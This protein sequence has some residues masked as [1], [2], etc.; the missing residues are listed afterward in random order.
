MKIFFNPWEHII[1]SLLSSCYNSF[2]TIVYFW[3]RWQFFFS[4]DFLL[5]GFFLVFT[6]VLIR[7]WHQHKEPLKTPT[8]WK[9][10][11][12]SLRGVSSV[13]PS[14]AGDSML[15]P[16]SETVISG[17]LHDECVCGGLTH[18]MNEAPSV[19]LIVTYDNKSL[20]KHF[21]QK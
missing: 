17:C 3:F 2:T 6:A 1:F 13:Q 20:V 7:C 5:R 11:D 21:I 12:R 16:L 18:R 4:P 15:K 10:K 14:V 19:L 8:T 9:S